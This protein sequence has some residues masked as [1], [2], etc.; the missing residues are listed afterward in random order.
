MEGFPLNYYIIIVVYK[1]LRDLYLSLILH[2]DDSEFFGYVCTV[3]C[4][5]LS[6]IY[7]FMLKIMT[8]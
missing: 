3:G 8:V 6:Y 4:S 2:C 5:F 1:G 7:G